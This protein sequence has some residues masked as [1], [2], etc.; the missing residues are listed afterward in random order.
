MTIIPIRPQFDLTD[1]SSCVLDLA[2]PKPK[3]VF[4]LQEAIDTAMRTGSDLGPLPV[5]TGWNDITPTIAMNL[6]H[7]NPPGHNRR[8]DPS[9]V[10]YYA[11]QIAANDWKP[12]G[13]PVLIDTNENLADAQ[14]RLYA[15]LISGRMFKSFVITGIQPGLFA[16]IDN[17]AARTAK[18][19][20]QTAGFDGVASIIVNVIKFSEKVKHGVFNHV[21]STRLAPFSPA[22]ILRL[23]ANYPNAKKAARSAASD[24]SD[25]SDLLS[26][27]KDV[28]A[29]IGMKIIELY[30]EDVA[31]EFFENIAYTGEGA[32]DYSVALHREVERDNRADKGMPKHHTAA[33]LIKIFN[34]WKGQTSLGR[35]WM[36]TINEDFP[37]FDGNTP[38]T[39]AAE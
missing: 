37:A 5:Q 28:V 4:A 8:L 35:R 6:L 2:N 21:G 9:K 29:Y 13:Q 27:R 1:P 14:H 36:P 24:W 25:V 32:S 20:L 19:A 12:T 11:N 33:M 31:D 38:Q 3:E 30:D 34:A 15:G 10:F 17:A 39:E 22:D 26:G 16:Y 18:D 7:R 23:V